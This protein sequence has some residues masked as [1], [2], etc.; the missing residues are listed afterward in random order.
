MRPK[1]KNPARGP[2][3]LCLRGHNPQVCE[4]TQILKKS[5]RKL[6]KVTFRRAESHQS[7]PS[8]AFAW[9]QA[10]AYQV[11]MICRMTV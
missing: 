3:L 11:S 5:K 7:L 8:F 10:S 9:Y 6:L 4:F 2:G 1:K